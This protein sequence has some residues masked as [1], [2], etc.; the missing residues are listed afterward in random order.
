[1]EELQD[2]PPEILQAAYRQAREW[3]ANCE[4]AD[5]KLRLADV[6][7]RVFDSI[8][9][10]LTADEATEN[11][12]T[13]PG[14]L[15]AQ[16]EKHE[17]LVIKQALAEVDGRVTYAASLLDMRYQSLAYIIESRHPDLLKKRTPI[18][19]RQRNKKN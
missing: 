14:G 3:L 13:E 5:I 18:R 4:S 12:M 19:R 9:T 11:L 6:A 1:M 2:L 17:R 8:H 7:C 16:L 10:E 15:Q